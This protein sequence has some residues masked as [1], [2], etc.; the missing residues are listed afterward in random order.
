M[1]Y[2]LLTAT[3]YF[4]GN[5]SGTPFHHPYPYWSVGTTDCCYHYFRTQEKI[6]FI[7]VQVAV[8]ILP[9]LVK[10]EDSGEKGFWVENHLNVRT[11]WP[12]PLFK[13]PP[14][15]QGLLTQ[16]PIILW[17]LITLSYLELLL[18]SRKWSDIDWL[19]D[20]QMDIWTDWQGRNS[21]P[22][23]GGGDILKQRLRLPIEFLPLTT[24]NIKSKMY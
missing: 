10:F 12:W 23:L 8:F 13:W 17:N 9:H 21:F 16:S 11:P 5:T 24:H 3:C 15:Q 6:L 14:K 19:R 18:F 4:I 20:G 2:C 1:I 7:L 22:L